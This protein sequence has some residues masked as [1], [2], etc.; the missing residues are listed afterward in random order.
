ML[1]TVIRRSSL[2]AN[3]IEK[4]EIKYF[5]PPQYPETGRYEKYLACF[6]GAKNIEGVRYTFEASPPYSHQS[7]DVF[8]QV[9]ERIEQTLPE[10]VVVVCVRHPVIRAYSHY[11]HNL[12]AFG[13][14]GDGVHNGRHLLPRRPFNQG[15][16]ESAF[17][18]GDV[19]Q[20]SENLGQAKEMF[21]DRL[22]LFF[23]EHDVVRFGD[24]L[25]EITDP[26][27]V[28]SLRLGDSPPSAV[29]PRRPV[30]NYEIR[31]KVLHA[32]GSR[33]GEHVAYTDES[34][35]VKK[36]VLLSRNSWTLKLEPDEI[37]DLCL[38]YFSDDMERSARIT[39]DTRFMDYL[40]MALE[41]EAASLSNPSLLDTLH[42]EVPKHGS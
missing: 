20:Y 38:K 6:G 25:G 31:D 27:V 35:P 41:P 33:K 15:F 7:A 24:W 28:E 11:I 26:D 1:D 8:R 12:H 19:A 32:F 14:Y 23:L 30:P 22:K 40:E 9:L 17:G 21:G 3:P 39:G 2:V 34:W 29:I 13:L 10:P 18:G 42:A 36:K 4:K 5:L 16:V 37:R